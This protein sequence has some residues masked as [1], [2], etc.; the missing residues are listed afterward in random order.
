MYW[1]AHSLSSRRRRALQNERVNAMSKV[2]LLGNV[3]THVVECCEALVA[4]GH[5]VL[6]VAPEV[7]D[8]AG[9]AGVAQVAADPSTVI[10]R[11][12]IG[13]LIRQRGP[14]DVVLQCVPAAAAPFA[15]TGL[16]E[17]AELLAALSLTVSLAKGVLGASLPSGVTRLITLRQVT[18]AEALDDA[19]AGFLAGFWSGFAGAGR[20]ES[21]D[22]L[23]S[24]RDWSEDSLRELLAP[25]LAEGA[26]LAGE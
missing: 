10:G 7:L 21:I 25:A 2:L 23:K 22:L 6:V 26:S 16:D 9:S 14:F 3:E 5:Q 15:V 12:Q 13:D 1:C 18:G 20:L 11:G 19:V 17:D 4:M 24:D 8:R